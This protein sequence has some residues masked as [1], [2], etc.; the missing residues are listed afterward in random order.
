M[1]ASRSSRSIFLIPE[2]STSGLT[3]T[4]QAAWPA[5]I[6]PNGRHATGKRILNNLS[7]SASTQQ[8]SASTQE[9]SAS[10]QEIAAS[11]QALAGTAEQLARLVQRFKVAA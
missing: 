8:V 11:A 5:G 10:T 6:W 4:R 2:L 7:F 9:T 1:R 3:T